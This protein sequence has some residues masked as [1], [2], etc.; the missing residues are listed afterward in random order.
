MRSI[1][2]VA[3]LI[4]VVLCLSIATP[5][6]AAALTST[7]IQAILSLLS[8]FGADQGTINN[9][10]ASLTG[11]STATPPTPPMPSDDET[12]GSTVSS[13]PTLT[14][15]LF[16][17]TTD[18][19]TNGEVSA[20]QGFLSDY[21]NLS[22]DIIVGFYGAKTELYV[23]KFQA[24]M[25][26]DQVG[27]V[28]KLTRAAIARVCGGSSPT[29]PPTPTGAAEIKV[30]VDGS[31]ML[32]IV[33]NNLPLSKITL[34]S[35]TTG[36]EFSGD[37]NVSGSGAIE[38]NYQTKAGDSYYF[39]VV[40]HSTGR[41]VAR[42]NI[43]YIGTSVPT[44][45]VL[46]SA[47]PNS[48][49]A[50]LKV[51]FTSN[52]YSTHDASEPQ[53]YVDFG[54]GAESG[55][56]IC[57][58]ST[59]T[60]LG[61]YRC[62]EW[63]I[64]HTYTSSGTYTAKLVRTVYDSTCLDLCT[65]WETHKET[66]GTATIT[67]GGTSTT[68]VTIITP[69]EEA[70]Y[71]YG[72]QLTVSW[73]STGSFPK[74]STACV[75]LRNENT[76]NSFAF[77]SGGGNCVGVAGLEPLR[78]V[79]G[80]II[81]TAGYDLAP[82]SYRAVVRVT[83]PATSDG[84]DGALLATDTSDK[85]FKIVDSISTNGISVTAPNGGEQWEIG[86]LNTITW[87][88]Y[89]Y[90]PDVNPAKD[91]NVF[92]ERLDGS[93]A[94]QI[95]DTGKAS[96]HTYFNIGGYNNWAEPGQYR[97]YVGNRVTGATDRSDGTFT[98]LPRGV[99]IKVN[100]SDGPVTLTDNQK[101]TVSI[102][103]G[104]NFTNCTLNGVRPTFGGNPGIS[105]GQAAAG[106]SS[107]SEGYA[108][109]PT[110]G[111]GTSIYLL[112][113]KADGS[114]RSDSVQVNIGGTS[115]SL[116]VTSPNGGEQFRINGDPVEIYWT[117]KGIGSASI[118]LYKN[119]QW[120]SWINKT[121][122][123][124]S[125]SSTSA[126]AD[127]FRY[128]WNFLNP[129]IISDGDLGKNIF[130]IYITGQKADGTGYIDDKSDAPFGFSASTP[131][132]T[133]TG[134]QVNAMSC[135]TPP[136]TGLGAGT[137]ACYG[138]W[139]FSKEFGDDQN[140]CPTGSNGY[141]LATTG[142]VIATSACASGK[143]T[144]SRVVDIYTPWHSNPAIPLATT[145]EIDQYARNLNSTSAAV[146]KQIIRLWEY[147]CSGAPTVVTTSVISCAYKSDSRTTS[148]TLA[149]T[150]TPS[151]GDCVASCKVTR[152]E[153]YGIADSGTC[154]FNVNGALTLTHI[155][156]EAL[157]DLGATDLQASFSQAGLPTFSAK[158]T[159]KGSAAATT[160][161]NLFQITDTALSKTLVYFSGNAIT[162]LGAGASAT[163]TSDSTPLLGTNPYTTP[164][165]Y[166]VRACANYRAPYWT[167]HI[168]EADDAALSNLRDYNCTGWSEISNK[169]Q[170][171]VNAGG[172]NN[173][174]SAAAAL[175]DSQIQSILNFLGVF[176]A[177]QSV[178]TNVNTS[179]RGQR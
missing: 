8:S 146:S 83:A 158:I 178:I 81:R 133:T 135:S 58:N 4:A 92:L 46:F 68:G 28:G 47:S 66:L 112:C 160:F 163:I 166:K 142:C 114:T 56:I 171:Q 121:V 88:P 129:P 155:V 27:Y 159:N 140:M 42:S 156:G 131:T 3:P 172:T 169:P 43:F 124:Q 59:G 98:L 57:L 36:K 123:D 22:E 148:D 137:L 168:P 134:P 54:D 80:T 152:N 70:Y 13:C 15:T 53:H 38:G 141:S 144:A 61:S 12:T 100:G 34:V 101:V 48:G 128:A 51:R 117:Q 55:R 85:Y 119:D 95:M 39:K 173:L 94:G 132:Q 127:S 104:A 21:F 60:D 77:P 174:A 45:S 116:Q 145:A 72:Q 82:G 103:T 110:P 105:L 71:Y 14:R 102:K 74:G 177:D 151:N 139:D 11:Q 147:S 52:K 96:L 19:N 73:N 37:D 26:I 23:K 24:K 41:E 67:V 5:A 143:A 76:G 154:T 149:L 113:K 108:Y 120:Y 6:N 64:E 20:L 130:K 63:G 165:T 16:R 118:A 109:A 10:N 89:G 65:P 167:E 86:Q 157:P 9:V 111:S 75:T 69:N 17:G 125:F 161:Q 78:S 136:K 162:S 106:G 18:A 29:T 122:T 175:S 97:V 84:R 99:D 62:L 93:T 150:Q 40:A 30:D 176:G 25:G 87:S 2:I 32:N 1:K 138:L 126:G 44:N 49:L 90:N 33:Y 107:F 170:G 7:Q 50:P 35:A 115:A 164:G 179:L 79:T 31:Y 91:V 153:K